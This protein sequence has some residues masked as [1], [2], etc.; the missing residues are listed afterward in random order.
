MQNNKLGMMSSSCTW[1]LAKVSQLLYI[2]T[3][4]GCSLPLLVCPGV[5]SAHVLTCTKKCSP[6]VLLHKKCCT[7]WVT[8]YS[9]RWPEKASEIVCLN[10]KKVY[11]GLLFNAAVAKEHRDLMRST[12]PGSKAK[13]LR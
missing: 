6:T 13:D 4:V 2:G 10:P 5:L 9:L 3:I 1:H 7:V 12:E 11:G 8:C